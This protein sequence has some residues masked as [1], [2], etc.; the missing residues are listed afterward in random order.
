MI[1]HEVPVY[2]QLVLSSGHALPTHT[3]VAIVP[4]HTCDDSFLVTA[5]TLW[6]LYLGQ[7]VVTSDQCRKSLVQ[8]ARM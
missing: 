6:Q 1:K 4:I 3:L 5:R 2:R 8:V 7:P